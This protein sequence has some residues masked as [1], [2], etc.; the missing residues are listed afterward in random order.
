MAKKTTPI[1]IVKGKTYKNFKGYWRTVL[2]ICETAQGT[3]VHY[4]DDTNTKRIVKIDTFRQ[5]IKKNYY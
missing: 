4:I 2:D 3:T 1:E 5:W